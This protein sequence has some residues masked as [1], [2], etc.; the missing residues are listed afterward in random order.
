MSWGSRRG[1]SND[2][3]QWSDGNQLGQEIQDFCPG[4]CGQ[5]RVVKKVDVGGPWCCDECW[6]KNNQE[7]R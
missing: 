1:R 2:S 5:Y 4:G 6:R 3:W 7:S